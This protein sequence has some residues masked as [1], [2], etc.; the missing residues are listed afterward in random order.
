MAVFTK[1][2]CC[3][4]CNLKLNIFRFLKQSEL[5]QINKDR[6]EVQFHKDENIFKQGGPLTHIACLTSGLAKVYCESQSGKYTILRI[7]PIVKQ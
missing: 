4:N 2:E 1:N 6:F 3:A 7:S 5:E